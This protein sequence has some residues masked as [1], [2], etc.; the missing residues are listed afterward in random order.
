MDDT[1]AA[2]PIIAL[3]LAILALPSS[4]VC[5]FILAKSN[6]CNVVG[7][8]RYN[9]GDI[10]A[11]AIAASLARSIPLIANFKRSK[12]VIATVNDI[13]IIVKVLTILFN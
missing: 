5:N 6:C 7:K 11:A 3:Y 12:N 4:S 1:N 2:P 8:V 9:G 10:I 13:V